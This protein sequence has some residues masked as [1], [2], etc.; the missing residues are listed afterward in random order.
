M[1]FYKSRTIFG[2]STLIEFW[3]SPPSPLPPPERVRIETCLQAWRFWSYQRHCPVNLD[4]NVP[5]LLS[6]FFTLQFYQDVKDWWLFG[7]YFCMPLVC[8]AIFYT[9]MTCEMLNRRNGSLRI[10]LSE[11][12]KQVNL[13][14]AWQLGHDWF[15]PYNRKPIYCI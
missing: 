10:A 11:H 9:L 6:L 2:V 4:Y 12:L 7:F 3:A 5:P 8:T 14:S 1:C 15:L 13:I